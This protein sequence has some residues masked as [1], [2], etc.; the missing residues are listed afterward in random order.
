MTSKAKAMQKLINMHSKE[1]LI[2]EMIQTQDW[3]D[4]FKQYGSVEA[5]RASQRTLEELARDAK[6]R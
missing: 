5:M 4:L 1:L 6:N 2:M 3:V